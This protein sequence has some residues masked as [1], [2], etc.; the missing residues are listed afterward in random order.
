[1]RFAGHE[2]DP[3]L[4]AHKGGRAARRASGALLVRL[5]GRSVARWELAGRARRWRVVPHSAEAACRLRRRG[6]TRTRSRGRAPRANSGRP[7]AGDAARGTRV[8][9]CVAEL[10]LGR[11]APHA[12]GRRRAGGDR[13]DWPRRRGA[14]HASR[15]GA[16]A[17]WCNE[18]GTAATDGGGAAA[19]ACSRQSARLSA[20][21]WRGQLHV[22]ESVDE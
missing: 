19:R 15:C 6:E 14:H 9:G 2:C 7:G 1:M 21:R 11:H 4:E 8:G 22:A 17:S 5:D 16:D 3:N 20:R 10:L 13:A 12:R 18:V